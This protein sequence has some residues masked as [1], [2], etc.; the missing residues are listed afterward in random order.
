MLVIFIQKVSFRKYGVAYL[1]LMNV[2]RCCG[3]CDGLLVMQWC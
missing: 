3:F 1:E 2:N